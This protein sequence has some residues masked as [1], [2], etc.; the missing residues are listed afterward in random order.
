MRQPLIAVALLVGAAGMCDAQSLKITESLESLET[1]ARQD[2]NDAAAQFNLALGYWSKKRYNDAVPPLRRAIAIDPEFAPA[3]FALALVPIANGSAF[4]KHE[5]PSIGY[6]FIYYTAV[7]SVWKEFDRQVRRAFDIDPLVDTR[8]EVSVEWR[9]SFHDD[10]ERGIHEYQDGKY[11][12]AIQHLDSFIKDVEPHKDRHAQLESG[13]WYRALAELRLTRY[14]A[15]IRDLR[16]LVE[17]GQSQEAADT[18]IHNPFRINEYR[19]MLAFAQQRAGQ[20]NDAIT[21][22]QEVLGNDIGFY[23]AHL[24]L[25]EIYESHR[26]WDQAI[27]ERQRAIEASPEN[28][29]L[30]LYLGETLAN[31]GQW[32]EAEQPLQ[33][34]QGANPHDSRIPYFLGRVEQQLGKAEA[35]KDAYRRFLAIAP[36]RYAAQLADARQRLAALQ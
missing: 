6:R 17:A 33:M 28:P 16:R 25:A 35:A 7:D 32:I 19:Y 4:Q 29:S 31:A 22:Y 5:I 9:G 24:R 11:E 14:D 10:F 36:S 30:E 12:Q 21:L 8:I 23:S 18:L 2:S 3:Y 1:S 26:M 27:Q 15:A 34:A 13:L 20:S